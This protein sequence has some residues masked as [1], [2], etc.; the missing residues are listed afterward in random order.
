M[1]TEI[2]H[3]VGGLTTLLAAKLETGASPTADNAAT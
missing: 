2:T 3:A 1:V